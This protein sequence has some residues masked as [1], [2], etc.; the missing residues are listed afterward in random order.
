[1][2]PWA[3]L[4]PSLLT[5]PEVQAVGEAPARLGRVQHQVGVSDVEVTVGTLR[6]RHQFQLLDPPHLQPRLLARSRKLGVLQLLRHGTCDAGRAEVT[7]I[8][9]SAQG[10]LGEREPARPA[11][12]GLART[13][14][15]AL[16]GSQQPRPTPGGNLHLRLNPADW[17]SR[18]CLPPDPLPPKKISK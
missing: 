8:A 18:K 13:G 7:G 15:G 10:A 4:C 6:H 3:A 11:F 1:M 14:G 5:Q 16:Q 17:N 9:P 2:G 12:K